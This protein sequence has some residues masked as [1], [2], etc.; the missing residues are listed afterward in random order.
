MLKIK[1][2][3]QALGIA[4]ALMLSGTAAADLNKGLVAYWSFDDCTANDAGGNG[5]HGILNGNISCTE[6]MINKG[7]SFDGV[8][9][10]IDINVPLAGAANWSVCAW[11]NTAKIDSNA[12]DWQTIVAASDK[13]EAATVKMGFLTESAAFGIY[14]LLTAEA[15]IATVNKNSFICY[16]KSG[17]SLNS[18]KDGTTIAGGHSS[19]GFTALKTIGMWQPSASSPFDK[20]PFNG[21]LDELRVYSRALNKK[22]IQQLSHIGQDVS[23]STNGYAALNVTCTNKTSGQSVVFASTNTPTSTW[24]C[25]QKG[26]AVNPGDQV[27]VLLSGWAHLTG[28][29]WEKGNWLPCNQMCGGGIQMRSVTCKNPRGQIVD[30][31]KCD[32]ASRPYSLQS[33]NIQFCN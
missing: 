21:I 26:L 30:S 23:G 12:T 27:D 29:F 4:A 28:F 17:N 19:P 1:S 24:N 18:I 9:S 13:T 2:R 32:S 8:D 3:I 33:C 7:L 22:E 14:P 20:A 11:L 10:Y 15:K 6:G 5:Y 16:T 25:E 31:A